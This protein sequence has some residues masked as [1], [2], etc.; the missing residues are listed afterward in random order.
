MNS[1]KR[2]DNIIHN[3]YNTHKQN[4]HEYT[5]HTPKTTKNKPSGSGQH[6]KLLKMVKKNLIFKSLKV[7]K[8]INT[9]TQLF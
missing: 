3:Q 6:Q 4:T 5:T 2:T 8:T 7:M 9:I 1:T